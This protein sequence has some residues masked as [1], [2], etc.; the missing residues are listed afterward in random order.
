MNFNLKKFDELINSNKKLAELLGRNAE[1]E[2]KKKKVNP[3]IIAL[4]VVGGIAAI[5]G[6]AYLVYRFLTPDDYD[7][8]DDFDEDFEDDS[9]VE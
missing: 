8:F 3:F 9:I 7:D 5:A 2:E 6:I 4:A 1:I